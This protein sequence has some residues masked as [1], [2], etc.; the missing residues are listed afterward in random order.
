MTRLP[1]MTPDDLQAHAPVRLLS[2]PAG[3]TSVPIA[4]WFQP[5]RRSQTGLDDLPFCRT[6]PVKLGIWTDAPTVV[7]DDGSRCR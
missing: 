5:A 1:I 7:P 6:E 3:V 2:V 4:R